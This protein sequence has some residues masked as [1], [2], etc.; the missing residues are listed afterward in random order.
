MK[1]EDFYLVSKIW[2]TNHSKKRVKES[3]KETLKNLKVDYLDLLLIH[4]PMGF[5]VNNA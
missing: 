2:S 5:K 3:L 1:R 4:W